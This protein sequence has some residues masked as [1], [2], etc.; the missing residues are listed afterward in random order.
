VL[1]LVLLVL[2]LVVSTEATPL[3]LLPPQNANLTFVGRNDATDSIL[4]VRSILLDKMT[5]A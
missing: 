5:S 4:T 2:L 1:V 3:Q